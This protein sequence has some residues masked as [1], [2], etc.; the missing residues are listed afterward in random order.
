MLSKL[1]IMSL[2]LL[3]LLGVTAAPSCP[4]RC[5]PTVVKTCFK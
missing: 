5:G 4:G 3:V 1:L 2:F